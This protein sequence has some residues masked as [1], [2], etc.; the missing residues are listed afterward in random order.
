MIHLLLRK[1]FW[2]VSGIL[3]CAMKNHRIPPGFTLLET[4]IASALTIIFIT[5]IVQA[6]IL[7][8]DV[9]RRCR[10]EEAALETAVSA[11]ESLKSRPFGHSLLEERSWSEEIPSTV[12]PVNILQNF[13]IVDLSPSLKRIEIECRIPEWNAFP[14][15]AAVVVSKELGF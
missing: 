14:I 2:H 8:L 13:R 10:A 7:A 11:L 6:L 4:L 1:I 3:F 15:R 9:N 5:G 12:L